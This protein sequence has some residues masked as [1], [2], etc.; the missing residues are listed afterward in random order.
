MLRR[1][2]DVLVA[3]SPA[4]LKTNIDDLKPGGTLVVNTDAFTKANLRK[5]RP[6]LADHGQSGARVRVDRRVAPVGAAAVPGQLS[7]HACIGHPP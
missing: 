5:A 4:A 7:D 3:M 6:V 1:A 2:R